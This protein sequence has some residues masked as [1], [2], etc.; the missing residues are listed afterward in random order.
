MT[1]R[2]WACHWPLLFIYSTFCMHVYVWRCESVCASRERMGEGKLVIN[3][4]R[5]RNKDEK[6]VFWIPRDLEAFAKQNILCI[7]NV[8]VWMCVHYSQINSRHI[9]RHFYAVHVYVR[10]NV[11]HHVKC[12]IFSPFKLLSNEFHRALQWL[13]TYIHYIIYAT[14]KLQ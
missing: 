12:A 2:I 13:K 6:R 5:E 3:R 14:C 1:E 9:D 11:F 8:C 10:V 7:C 4:E